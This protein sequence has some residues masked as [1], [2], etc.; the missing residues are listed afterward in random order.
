MYLV[1]KYPLEQSPKAHGA[2]RIP[3]RPLMQVTSETVESCIMVMTKRPDN[4]YYNWI[5]IQKYTGEHL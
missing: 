3:I 5:P 2:H 1:R 4:A